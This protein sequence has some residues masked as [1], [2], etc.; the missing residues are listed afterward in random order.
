VALDQ[1][2]HRVVG[3]GPCDEAALALDLPCH[4]DFVFQPIVGDDPFTYV[5]KTLESG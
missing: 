2:D 1:V 5:A 4:R 3:L